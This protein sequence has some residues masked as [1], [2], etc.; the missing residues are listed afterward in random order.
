M[1]N[2]YFVVKCDGCGTK[3]DVTDALDFAVGTCSHCKTLLPDYDDFVMVHGTDN[4]N[5]A[6]DL[7]DV[8]NNKEVGELFCYLCGEY[9]GAGNCTC[10]ASIRESVGR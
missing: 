2:A 1:S 9:I 7:L 3:L 4:Y 5:K 10:Y 6:Y 8:L